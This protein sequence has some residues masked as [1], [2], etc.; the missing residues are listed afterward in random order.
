MAGRVESHHSLKGLLDIKR[1]CS[2]QHR[3]R[4]VYQGWKETLWRSKYH[5]EGISRSDEGGDKRGLRGLASQQKDSGL[6]PLCPGDP[7]ACQPLAPSWAH[8]ARRL[9]QGLWEVTGKVIHAPWDAGWPKPLLP[10]KALP[11]RFPPTRP[12]S[13]ACLPSFL[14][15]LFCSL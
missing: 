6:A 4:K 1:N 8:C 12:P 11:E 9:A 14:E 15:T 5:L 2:A 13:W 7:P 10:S 3:V